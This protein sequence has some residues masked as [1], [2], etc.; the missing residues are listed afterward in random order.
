MF[1]G[2][3]AT[4]GARG[5]GQ[6]PGATQRAPA[7]A[8]VC[9]DSFDRHQPAQPSGVLIQQPI[10]NFVIQK[11][12]TFMSGFFHRVG[13]TE[14]RFPFSTPNINIRN[15]KIDISAN[16]V[17][18]AVD[19]PWGFYTPTELAAELETRLTA[20][21]AAVTWTVT[22]NEESMTFTI[23]GDA[24]FTI[25]P[26]DFTNTA[27]SL[28]NRLQTRKGLY[29]MMNWADTSTAALTF[30]SLA[31]P[32][33]QYTSYV[34]ICSRNLTQ[35]QQSKD[36]SSREN[37]APGLL[38]RLYLN[39]FTNENLGDGDTSAKLAWPGC[40]GQMVHRLF[41]APKMSAWQPGSFVDQIDIVLLDDVGN[42]LLYPD[43]INTTNDFQITLLL[44][45]N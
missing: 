26:H 21:I 7:T 19:L 40:R 25:A 11:R 28:G 15:N 30:T 27:A 33:M 38:C 37:Q 14:I 9:V 24:N 12:Q 31:M 4:E 44:S 3:V 41:P 20:L 1:N 22:Y 39:N 29:Y 8:F 2:R 10:N 45:E 18:V 42:P 16:G 43:P 35:F 13:L 17:T 34:D 32:Q 6:D 5:N 23:T 36:S